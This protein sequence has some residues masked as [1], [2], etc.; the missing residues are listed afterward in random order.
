QELVGEP[1]AVLLEVA[2]RL[3]GWPARP[4]EPAHGRERGKEERVEVGEL[5]GRQSG[6]REERAQRALGVAAAMMA[7]HVLRAPEARERRRG[8]RASRGL[9]AG[10]RRARRWRAANARPGAGA[11]GRRGCAGGRE[12]TSATARSRRSAPRTRAPSATPA[13]LDAVGEAR[14]LALVEP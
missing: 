5:G 6:A 1:G 14:G 2:R 10:R 9:R 4:G 12:T 13:P 8:S 11:A 3:G 7:H